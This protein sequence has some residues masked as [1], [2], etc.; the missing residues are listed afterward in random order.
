MRGGTEIE[1]DAAEGDGTSGG[2]AE[3]LRKKDKRALQISC[4]LSRRARF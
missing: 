2:W 4:P 3:E 1:T